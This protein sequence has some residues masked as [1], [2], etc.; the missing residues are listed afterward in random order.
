MR[1]RGWAGD[2]VDAVR[3]P[4]GITTIDNTCVAVAREL[5]IREIPVRVHAPTDP[6][7]PEMIGRFGDA[8]TW[9]E[10][11]LHRTSNQRPPLPPT[12]TLDAPRMPRPGG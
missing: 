7:P 2:P 9:G 4:D 11:L 10:A 6:L 1:E 8:R 5:G 3:T 12:G